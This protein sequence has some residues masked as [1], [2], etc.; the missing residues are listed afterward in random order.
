MRVTNK[1][2]D[3]SAHVG[4]EAVSATLGISLFFFFLVRRSLR[5]ILGLWYWSP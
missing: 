3:L 1:K 5:D 4:H 2:L